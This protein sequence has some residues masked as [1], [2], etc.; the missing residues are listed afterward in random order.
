MIYPKL[1]FGRT[2]VN[3]RWFQCFRKGAFK[4]YYKVFD[5]GYGK[6]WIALHIVNESKV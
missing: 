3:C 4:G 5:V 6:F 2:T 1:M